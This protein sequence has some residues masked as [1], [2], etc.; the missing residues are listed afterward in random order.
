MRRLPAILLLLL[1]LAACHSRPAKVIAP[2]K[3]EDL[4]VDLYKGEAIIEANRNV[5]KT[6]SLKAVVKQSIFLKHGVTQEEYDSSMV[7]YGHNV[8][9]YMKVYDNVV[10]R[11][12]DEEYDLKNSGASASRKSAR[13]LTKKY[14][15]SGDSA[16][17]WD[18]EPAYV[19][20]PQYGTNVLRFDYNTKSDDKNGD[21]YNLIFRV[22]NATSHV[23]ALIGVDYPDGTSSLAY[24]N[25]ASEGEN[26]IALQC[27]STKRI[28]RVYGYITARP[29]A[30]EMIFVDSIILLRTRLDSAQYRS[31]ATQRW[32]GPERLR[33]DSVL[34]R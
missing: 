12:E 8:K 14:L 10:A 5:Y 7:W 29:M 28:R 24:R 16:D 1:L 15:S 4:L 3:L 17:I 33:P 20:M 2:D 31:F 27:D 25:N 30:R 34:K 26:I 19:L 13:R 18:K 21:R 6:D 9:A 23:K 22:Q 32:H 11:L